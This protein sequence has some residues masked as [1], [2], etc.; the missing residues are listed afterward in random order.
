MEV[1]YE[2]LFEDKFVFDSLGCYDYYGDTYKKAI[3]HNNKFSSRCIKKAY[4]DCFRVFF[5]NKFDDKKPN[6]AMLDYKFE[7]IYQEQKDKYN[8]VIIC[9]S[10][11][12]VKPHLKEANNYFPNKW[13]SLINESFLSHD[14]TSAKKAIADISRF[15]KKNKIKLLI[16]GNDKL[17]IEKALIIAATNEKIPVVIIE[18]GIYNIDS[19]RKNKSAIHCDHFWTWSQHIK[20]LYINETGRPSDVV[21][22][23][24]Y[25]FTITDLGQ[26]ERKTVL[27]IGN[28][29][30]SLN[31]EEGIQYLNIAKNVY[32]ICCE[33]GIEFK[34]RPHPTE[35]ID[36]DYKELLATGIEKGVPLEK[37]L[38]KYDVVIG[39][40]SSVLVEAAMYGK[41]V[42]QIIWSDRSKIGLEDPLYSFTFKCT[43]DY[44]EMEKT[45]VSVVDGDERRTVDEYYL[46]TEPDFKGKISQ[47]LDEAIA[48]A[49]KDT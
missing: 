41:K 25:P 10:V 1:T 18:H 49:D 7:R 36:D 35:V 39:D 23:I 32:K 14:M 26:S 19:F 3:K 6:I 4:N 2:L 31:Y 27:F 48:K 15:Y 28:Y 40:V 29:Y 5:R 42:I 45:I 8:F 46:K 47:L 20:D 34:Y 30:K 11:R 9:N 13:L 44:S 38:S 43:G 17:F 24:G 21:D 22:V 37:D 16:L 12:K 33:H